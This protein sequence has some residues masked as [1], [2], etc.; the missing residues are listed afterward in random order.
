MVRWSSVQNKIHFSR[1]FLYLKTQFKIL[2]ILLTQNGFQTPKIRELLFVRSCDCP[3]AL[4]LAP[5]QKATLD[6]SLVS[7]RAIFSMASPEIEHT[8]TLFSCRM[9][10]ILSLLFVKLPPN[11]DW[12]KRSL[13]ASLSRYDATIF[14]ITYY[15]FFKNARFY[16]VKIFEKLKKAN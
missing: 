10:F 1:L 7:V 14:T 11:Q 3:V 15:T 5:P 4:V 13:L 9:R 8:Y 16:I 12:Y 2:S 6:W